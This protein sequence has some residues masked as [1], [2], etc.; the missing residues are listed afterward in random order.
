[1]ETVTGNGEPLRLTELE[2]EL[3]G[4]DAAAALAK[5]DAVLVGL[6]ERL[7]KAFSAGLP[8]DEYVRCERLKEANVVARKILRL[9]MAR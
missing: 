6:E 4:P 9:A 2:R 1:M 5:Y 7:K 3:S 8:P